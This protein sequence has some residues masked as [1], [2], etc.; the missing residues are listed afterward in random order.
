MK[1]FLA[2]VV[3]VLAAPASAFAAVPTMVVRDVPLHASRTL[4][5]AAPRFNM[6]GLHWRGAGAVYFTAR[7]LD[8]R[9]SAWVQADADDRVQNGW[10]L[11]G[12]DWT[13]AASALRIRTTGHVARVRAYYVDS[14]V[15]TVSG[16]RLQVAGSPLII[17]RFSWQADESIR[18]APPKYSDAVHYAVVHHTAGSNNYTRGQSAAIVR[19]IQSYHGKGN[20][21]N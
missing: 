2:I 1:S 16:R 13:G 11:G 20:G 7:T 5:A 3:A 12:L 4:G 9:W 19:G 8:G 15:E 18:R 10:Y 17:S 14:P 21:W 6:V